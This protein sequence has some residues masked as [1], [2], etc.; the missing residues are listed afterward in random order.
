MQ[1]T[2]CV[3]RH[4][5]AQQALLLTCLWFQLQLGCYS[6]K[7]GKLNSF[8][9]PRALISTRKEGKRV[10]SGMANAEVAM[11]LISVLG[12]SIAVV[13]G[14]R[15]RSYYILPPHVTPLST[16]VLWFSTPLR[17]RGPEA[18]ALRRIAVSSPLTAWS[19][20]SPRSKIRCKPASSTLD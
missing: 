8:T 13:K 6:K 15:S 1:I 16:A 4:C 19:A 11:A 9:S 3:F 18:G 14:M 5:V 20:H 17:R 10:H 2:L 7:A 12:K